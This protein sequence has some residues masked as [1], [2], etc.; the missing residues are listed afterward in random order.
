MAK[1][2][3][4][5]MTFPNDF[6]MHPKIA[7]LSVDA[8]W[9]FVEMNGYSRM[10]D[11]D[12]RI[13]AVMMHRMW[14][15]EVVAELVGSHA[16]RPL[17]FHDS[18]ADVYVIRDYAAH[19]Q[20]TTDREEMSSKRS[21]SGKLGAN[22]RW[23]GK[24]MASAMAN[25]WQTD[26]KGIAETETETETELTTRSKDLAVEDAYTRDYLQSLFDN[27]YAHWPKKVQRKQA[28]DRFKIAARTLDAEALHAH[29][30]KFGK[31]YGE[32]TETQFVPSLAAWLN[33]QR[34]T[35]SPPTARASVSKPSKDA[36]ALT[37]IEQG[38]AMDEA[39]ERKALSA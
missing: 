3:R 7:P 30:V 34:W 35:D 21:E 5:Y 27:A 1:D 32:T 13:P 28:F 33:G 26:G 38:R 12:G 31:A 8:K 9:A 25:G 39:D 22:K 20:T 36:R 15:A 19:Q 24:P 37:L 4:L 18:A 16:D 2:K 10:Q 11:L 17:M 6:W 14:A 23:N 29:V